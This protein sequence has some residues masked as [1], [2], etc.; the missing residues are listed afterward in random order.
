MLKMK[1]IPQIKK[2]KQGKRT[3][4]VDGAPFVALSGELHNSSSSSLR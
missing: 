3:F 1:E 2:D 4:L